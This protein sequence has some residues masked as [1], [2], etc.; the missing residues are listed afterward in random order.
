MLRPFIAALSLSALFTACADEPTHPTA[1]P[2]RGPARMITTAA[3]L[4]VTPTSF[5]Y[6]SVI[7]GQSSNPQ[8]Y[9]VENTGTDLLYLTDIAVSG[10]NAGDFVVGNRPSPGCSFGGEWG[11]PAGM[12]CYIGLRFVPTGTG[13]RT[14][15]LTVKSAVGTIE[16]QLTGTGLPTPAMAD[17]SMRMTGAVQGKSIAYTIGV[18]NNG[19]DAATSVEFGD[20]LPAGTAFSSM[21]APSDFACITPTAGGT[22]PVK[23]TVASLASGAS[24]TI[25]LVVRLGGATKGAVTN[26]A[27]I[28]SGVADPQMDNNSAIVTVNVGKK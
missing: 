24:R 26:T 14:A 18:T 25:Q 23:C 19:P 5:D 4:N 1:I 2:P 9:T 12:P 13:A 11:W 22:G 3:I 6:G 27:A 15:T 28:I 16:V 17:L 7:I 8:T 20:M 21:S 10:P